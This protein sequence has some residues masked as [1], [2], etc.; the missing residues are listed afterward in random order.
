MDFHPTSVITLGIDPYIHVGP[1]TLAWHG[2]TI[3]IGIAIGGWA[4]A[5]WARTEGL[6]PEPLWTIGVLAGVGGLVGGRLF[7]LAE[8][9]RA[10]LLDPGALFGT[11]GFTFDG[12]LILAALLIVLYVRRSG[13]STR[14][15]D[16]GAVGLPLGVAIGRIGDVINGEHY[17]NPSTFFLAV[18]NAH[19][20]A[21]TPN[22]TIAY[23][24]GGLYEVLLGLVI[25]AIVWPLRHRLRR[26]MQLLWLVLLLFAVGRFLE[27]FVRSDSPELALGLSNAQWTSI[28]LAI[29]SVVGL[30]AVSHRRQAPGPADPEIGPRPPDRS[31]E[32]AVRHASTPS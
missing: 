22:P 15:L 3:A 8:H 18:R 13:I 4:A 16:A 30:W 9:D 27:F 12:G 7:H 17:G 19:P 23:E 29:V 26:P 32:A 21:S 2:L 5:R 10:G 1:V 20:E 25:L 11:R 24:N 6:S 28:A 14:F 31:G